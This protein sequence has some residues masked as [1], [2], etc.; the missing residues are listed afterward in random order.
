MHCRPIRA[1]GLLGA[2][3]AYNKWSKRPEDEETPLSNDSLFNPSQHASLSRWF[4]LTW[5]QRTTSRA[6]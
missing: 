4:C 6:G 2:R 5:T 3:R 1:V